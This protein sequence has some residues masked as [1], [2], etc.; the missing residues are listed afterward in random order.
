MK[1]AVGG[2]AVGLDEAGVGAGLVLAPV[3]RLHRLP[4]R[5]RLAHLVGADDADEG[6]VGEDRGQQLGQRH[7]AVLGDVA[8]EADEL[9]EVAPHQLGAE[10]AVRRSSRPR[11]PIRGSGRRRRGSRAASAAAARSRS[12]ARRGGRGSTGPRRRGS[13]P[14]GGAAGREWRSA[15]KYSSGR[16]AT[17]VSP[18]AWQTRVLPLRG[19]AQTRYE[20]SGVI[21][22]LCRVS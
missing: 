16:P 7:V 11:S 18:S 1:V 20:R 3:R 14:P 9:A 6:E 19:V 12:S 21:G 4:Q 5:D 22:Y 15:S 8:D 10:D 17:P 2:G 13:I